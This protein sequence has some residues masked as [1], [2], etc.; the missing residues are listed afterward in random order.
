MKSRSCQIFSDSNRSDSMQQN[1][2]KCKLLYHHFFDKLAFINCSI[3]YFILVDL[4]NLKVLMFFQVKCAVLKIPYRIGPVL[5]G[6][7]LGTGRSSR[8]F[9]ILSNMD[10]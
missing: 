4:T 9:N 5:L 3:I 1:G 2:C 8:M 6:G 10:H 7:K